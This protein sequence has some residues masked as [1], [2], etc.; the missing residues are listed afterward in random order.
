V[1]NLDECIDQ[2]VIQDVQIFADLPICENPSHQCHLLFYWLFPRRHASRQT[3]SPPGK[4]KLTAGINY[5]KQLSGHQ[6][7]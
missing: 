6:S 3:W 4:G 1:K 2:G 5:G 7:A